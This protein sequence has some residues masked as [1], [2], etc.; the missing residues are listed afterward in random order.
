MRMSGA[1]VGCRVSVMSGVGG[2]LRTLLAPLMTLFLHCPGTVLALPWPSLGLD[3]SVYAL[4]HT[5]AVRV[6]RVDHGTTLHPG[7]T[8]TRRSRTGVP[9]YHVCRASGQ[10]GAVGLTLGCTHGQTGRAGHLPQYP[11]P[12]L[13][14][15]RYTRRRTLCHPAQCHNGQSVPQHPALVYL[16]WRSLP[17]ANQA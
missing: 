14:A 7:Y 17:G 9:T 1:G 10:G 13:P 6:S 11:H 16:Y 12:I 8:C 2:R 5:G 15:D 3:T 4:V